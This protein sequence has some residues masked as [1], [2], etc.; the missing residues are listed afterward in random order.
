MGETILQYDEFIFSQVTGFPTP[1]VSRTQSMINLGGKRWAQET[2]IGLQGTITG[3]GF[4]QLIERQEALVSGFRKDYKSLTLK[5]GESNVEGFPLTNCKINNISFNSD[6]YTLMLDYDISLKSYE[7][8]FFSGYFGVIDPEEDISF[9]E[10]TDNTI[11][12]DHNIS[13]KGIP[14]N[15]KSSIQNAK[16]FVVAHTGWKNKIYPH[17]IKYQNFNFL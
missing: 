16:E 1:F 14:T 8:Q 15:G 2:E 10:N 4:S 5:E 13:A 17:F 3:T 11:A 6:K 9:S 7:S 12:I